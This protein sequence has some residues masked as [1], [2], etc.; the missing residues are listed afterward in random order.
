MRKLT[1]KEIKEKLFVINSDIEILSKEYKNSKTNLDCKCL[2]DGYIWGATWDNLSKGRGC[3]VCGVKRSSEKRSFTLGEIILKLSIINPNILI[4]EELK[5]ETGKT[6]KHVRRFISCKCKIDGHIW[7]TDWGN[8]SQGGGCP[9][10]AGT[11]KLKIEEIK[12]RLKIINPSIEILSNT[13]INNR[14]NLLCKC[15]VDNYEWGVPWNRLNNRVGCPKCN[16]GVKNKDTDY[17]KQ[18]LFNLVGNEYEVLGEY[19][20]INNK[21]LI[22]HKL[23]GNEYGILPNNF[24]SA[25]HRCSKCGLKNRRGKNHY[26]WKGGISNLSEYLREHM[27]A[28]RR[29]SYKKYNYKCDILGINSN[30]LIIH[31]LYNFSDIVQETMDMLSLP[32]YLEINEYT[33]EELKTMENLCLELHYKHGLG[34]CLSENEHKL[35]H[36]TCGIKNNTKNQYIE[37]KEMR[38]KEIHN[39]AS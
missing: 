30:N 8:L 21:I 16:G 29:D 10:C 26:N 4:L 12:E 19:K 27:I 33:E 1:L 7:E 38:L 34:V 24:L 23:C 2:I 37:F 15:K 18:E 9:K 17:F 13:Y 36:S 31:H 5:K 28:W 25:G 32:I 3:S 6:K 35:F 22:K 20:G 11:L 14:T 39:Q